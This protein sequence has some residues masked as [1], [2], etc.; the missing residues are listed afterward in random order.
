[1]RGSGG[2]NSKRFGRNS[3]RCLLHVVWCLVQSTTYTPRWVGNLPRLRPGCVL[4][5]FVG[6]SCGV[7]KTG[8]IIEQTSCFA[9]FFVPAVGRPN[10]CCCHPCTPP[11]H[12][13]HSKQLRGA[14]HCVMLLPSKCTCIVPVAPVEGKTHASLH[15]WRRCQYMEYQTRETVARRRRG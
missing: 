12:G 4:L 2:L 13:V 7:I 6:K 5:W 14:F 1:M 10:P 11:S 15:Y 8:V 3:H 9:F